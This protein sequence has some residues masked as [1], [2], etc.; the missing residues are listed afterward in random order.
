MVTIARDA[1]HLVKPDGVVRAAKSASGNR[2]A[3]RLACGV[4]VSGEG[5]WREGEGEKRKG[6]KG[7]EGIHFPPRL[8]H[9]HCPL[10]QG[11]V[12]LNEVM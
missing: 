1:V 9:S 2:G 7:G 6:G 5:R 4:G 10:D 11:K 3:M 12:Y 8:R